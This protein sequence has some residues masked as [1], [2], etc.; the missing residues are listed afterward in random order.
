M[1]VNM[2]IK[3]EQPR[4]SWWKVFIPYYLAP[5]L[6]GYELG[7]HKRVEGFELL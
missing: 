2:T 4:D 7:S 1:I 3:N 6:G 5:I